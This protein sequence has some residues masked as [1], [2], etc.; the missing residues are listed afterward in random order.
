MKIKGVIHYLFFITLFGCRTVPLDNFNGQIRIKQSITEE[1]KNK[2]QFLDVEA[3]TIPG[4]SL[5]KA[6]KEIIKNKKGKEIIVAVLDTEYDITH[7]DLKKS[8]WI[9]QNEIP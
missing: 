2:W 3:D 7:K 4:T 6:Y 5:N 8:I 1:Q 9:N